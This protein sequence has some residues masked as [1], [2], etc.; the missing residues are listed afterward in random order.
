[1]DGQWR[2]AVSSDGKYRVVGSADGPVVLIGRP[3]TR[4]DIVPVCTNVLRGHTDSVTSVA[5]STNERYVASG[6]GDHTVRLWSCPDGTM[7]HVFGSGPE[8]AQVQSLSENV[9]MARFGWVDGYGLVLWMGPDWRILQVQRTWAAASEAHERSSGDAVLSGAA[10]ETGE[11]AQKRWEWAVK[12]MLSGEEVRGG[13]GGARTIL[14]V[15][16]GGYR[17]VCVEDE[18]G[19]TLLHGS[20]CGG[21]IGAALFAL[22]SAGAEGSAERAALVSRRDKNGQTALH[23]CTTGTVAALLL[24][25]GA[26]AEDVDGQQQTALHV[27]SQHG[28]SDVVECLLS[29]GYPRDGAGGGLENAALLV[30]AQDKDGMTALHVASTVEVASKLLEVGAE[31]SVADKSGRCCVDALHEHVGASMWTA[32]AASILRRGGLHEMEPVGALQVECRIIWLAVCDGNVEV[33]RSVGKATRA[34]LSQHDAQQRTC[35]HV[36]SARGDVSIVQ[37]LLDSVVSCGTSADRSGVSTVDAVWKTELLNAQDKDG[38]TALH[39]TSSPE[40]MVWLIDSGADVTLVNHNGVSG[41]QH[42]KNS[43]DRRVWGS[44]VRRLGRA[45]YAAEMSGLPREWSFAKEGQVRYSRVVLVGDMGA[46]KTTLRNGLDRLHRV[47][48]WLR[49]FDVDTGDSYTEGAEF[50]EQEWS[51]DHVVQMVDCGGQLEYRSSHRMWMHPGPYVIVIV[52]DGRRPRTA[53][54]NAEAFERGSHSLRGSEKRVSVQLREWLHLVS[55]QPQGKSGGKIPVFV[56]VNVRDGKEASEDGGCLDGVESG[57]ADGVLQTSYV[58]RHFHVVGKYL[59]CNLF[60]EASVSKIESKLREFLL[61]P[62]T[63]S[64]TSMGFD[65]RG[66]RLLVE[67]H[68]DLGKFMTEKGM[69]ETCIVAAAAVAFKEE[70][71]GARMPVMGMA[72]FVKEYT[73]L[74]MH[75]GRIGAQDRAT[76]EFLVEKMALGGL[77]EGGIVVGIG[78]TG[79]GLLWLSPG[80]LSR[81][82]A[83]LT[84]ALVG[85]STSGGSGEVMRPREVQQRVSLR[86]HGRYKTDLDHEMLCRSLVA[87]EIGAGKS[88]ATMY[89]PWLSPTIHDISSGLE[90]RLLQLSKWRPRYVRVFKCCEDMHYIH[91]LFMPFM[92]V[93]VVKHF[94]LDVDQLSLCWQ[95]GICES[96]TC[97]GIE[98]P[99][100]LC[101]RTVKDAEGE[102]QECICI[103]SCGEDGERGIGELREQLILGVAEF[104]SDPSGHGRGMGREGTP[105][106]VE[107]YVLLMRDEDALRTIVL[108]DWPL[109][110][111]LPSSDPPPARLCGIARSTIAELLEQPSAAESPSSPVRPVPGYGECEFSAHALVPELSAA[112]LDWGRCVLQPILEAGNCVKVYV[113]FRDR[114]GRVMDVPSLALSVLEVKRPVGVRLENAATRETREFKPE[115]DRRDG[116]NVRGRV[117]VHDGGMIVFRQMDDLGCIVSVPGGTYVVQLVGM[118]GDGTATVLQSEQLTVPVAVSPL[119]VLGE[120]QQLRS[121]LSSRAEKGDVEDLRRKVEAMCAHITGM[122]RCSDADLSTLRATLSEVT[123][124]LNLVVQ[125]LAVGERRS[126]FDVDMLRQRIEECFAALEATS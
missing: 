54:E 101:W 29:R 9:Q 11:A 64:A 13:G 121:M 42:A 59:Q 85:R 60:D 102:E 122:K 40:I 46:G 32:V 108:G 106:S 105:V 76:V 4:T 94:K 5:I 17:G 14:Q 7:I 15:V 111:L 117:A 67:L 95:Q 81:V 20:S 26:C 51:G 93:R 98:I 23:M 88:L 44:I 66:S 118:V 41:L 19:Q 52:I 97:G 69:D 56:V 55:V 125:R 72:A 68:R 119:D 103:G 53:R 112:Q 74:Y 92:F 31:L 33:L 43:M 35:L 82:V 48:R 47:A 21:S 75:R 79:D 114:R 96:W 89:I 24:E 34:A 71:P 116:W 124:D 87:L 45:M 27:A 22:E 123:R 100:V 18:D 83:K 61:D 36:S 3:E 91:P 115:I 25:N 78:E 6:S 107:E 110:M 10:M 1:M 65:G 120:M 62:S 2:E 70:D 30:N 37:W 113:H 49:R 57:L 12:N 99:L 63:A 126:A 16:S 50:E 90:T 77:I 86:L 28:R 104:N 80:F 39:S 8:W 73:D 109:K 58:Q 38:K 84:S